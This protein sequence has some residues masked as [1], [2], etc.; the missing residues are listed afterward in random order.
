MVFQE[1][2][3]AHIPPVVSSPLPA[4]VSCLPISGN[5]KMSIAYCCVMVA[6]ISAFIGPHIEV[7]FI[8]GLPLDV[9]VL[10]LYKGLSQC[11]YKRL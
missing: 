10:S 11:I 5:G 8:H 6:E 4:I 9:L 1:P 3:D 7:I 2:E